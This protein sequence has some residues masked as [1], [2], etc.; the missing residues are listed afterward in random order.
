MMK[1]IVIA[2][3]ADMRGKSVLVFLR[4]LRPTRNIRIH[5]WQVLDLSAGAYASFDFDTTISACVS[6]NMR[7]NSVASEAVA[8]TPGELL[9]AVRPGGLSPKLMP[10]SDGQAIA[11]LTTEQSGVLN[12]T[13]P[14]LPLDCQW[15]VGGSPVLTVPG[16]D[17]GMTCTFEYD[18]VM[19]FMVAAPLLDGENFTVQTFTDAVPFYPSPDTSV[20]TVR[21]YW[22]R[23]RWLFDFQSDWQ[24]E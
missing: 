17:W 19:Y 14:P 18:P 3:V 16:V 8:V 23:N 13:Q 6:A 1:C 10:A 2:D 20:L 21:L 4:P 9:Q 12:M 7:G 15:R 5:A 22:E 11:R 24:A